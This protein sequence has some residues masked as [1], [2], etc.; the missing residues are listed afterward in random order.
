MNVE[1]WFEE[2]DVRKLLLKLY[3]EVGEVTHAYNRGDHN[4]ARKECEDVIVILERLME[5]L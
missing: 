4:H 2:V 3:E 1:K 5:V